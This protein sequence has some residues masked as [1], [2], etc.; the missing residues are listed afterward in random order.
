MQPKQKYDQYDQKGQK[1]PIQLEIANIT[2]TSKKNKYNQQEPLW[3]IQ[4][5][6]TNTTYYRANTMN[7]TRN[8]QYTIKDQYK[9]YN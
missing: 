2:N 7:T 3:S 8:Y 5:R 9:K 4:P 6:I 1:W